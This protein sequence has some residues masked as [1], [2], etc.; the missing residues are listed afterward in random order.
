MALSLQAN[1]FFLNGS[2]GTNWNA[3]DDWCDKPFN[4]H[5]SCVLW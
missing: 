1:N 3:A 4:M 5:L 2:I